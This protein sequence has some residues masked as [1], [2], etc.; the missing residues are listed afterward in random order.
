MFARSREPLEREADR[1]GALAVRGDVSNPAD[2]Q[3]PRREDG[4]GVR[5]HRRAREQLRRPAAH[6]RGRPDRRA[7]RGGRRAA[8]ALGDPAD[9][10]LPALPRQEPGRPR[11]QHHV[12]HRQGARRQP[13]ALEHGPPGRRRLGEDARP[14]GRAA[15]DHRELDRAGPDR[16]RADP[17]GLPRRPDRGGPGD[18][19][20]APPRHAARGRRRRL[21]PRLRPC[22]VRDGDVD[23]GRRRPD[24]RSLL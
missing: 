15:G 20:D 23:S 10:A 8:A 2:L 7:R 6:G 17:R 1:L 5:R 3:R 24:P 21:L 22:V 13:R 18:D 11:D 14:R 4:R 9:D 19:P 16:H 12:E